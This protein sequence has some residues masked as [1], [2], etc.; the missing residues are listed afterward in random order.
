MKFSLVSF[1][2]EREKS[3]NVDS[4][5]ERRERIIISDI[6]LQLCNPKPDAPVLER[7]A[8][9]LKK[10]DFEFLTQSLTYGEVV[11]ILTGRPTKYP[12]D[13]SD[14]FVTNNPHYMHMFAS[15][16][17]ELRSN[18]RL[19]T[20]SMQKGICNYFITRKIPVPNIWLMQNK[21][22]SRNKSRQKPAEILLMRNISGL[23][24]SW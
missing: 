8:F 19:P 20:F 10:I 17:E 7:Q 15:K 23:T 24:E 3:F 9:D 16:L 11:E 5:L 14:T 21:T 2:E 18:W 6:D 22:I 4:F 13:S 12:E 1:L